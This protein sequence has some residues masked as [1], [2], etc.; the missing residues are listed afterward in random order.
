MK[1]DT[2][3]LKQTLKEFLENE[4]WAKYYGNAP[5]VAKE[6]I[7]FEFYASDNDVDD[8]AD[9]DELQKEVREAMQEEDLKYMATHSP[10]ANERKYFSDMLNGKG[11]EAKQGEGEG[12]QD[13][14]SQRNGNGGADGEQTGGNSDGGGDGDG[15]GDDDGEEEDA[16]EIGGAEGL[17]IGGSPKPDDDDKGDDK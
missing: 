2:D 10:N 5:S 11:K 4:V 1:I 13:K 17:K 15:E 7:A 8:D 9:F 3:K 14:D 6:Y 16:G 12:T